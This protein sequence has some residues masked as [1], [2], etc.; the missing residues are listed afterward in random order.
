[1]KLYPDILVAYTFAD[2]TEEQILKYE[3]RINGYPA[4]Y[5]EVIKTS[6]MFLCELFYENKKWVLK[7]ALIPNYFF[8]SNLLSSIT[9][10][11]KVPWKIK[12]NNWSIDKTKNGELLQVQ[13][14]KKLNRDV[15]HDTATG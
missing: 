14:I 12:N 6:Q 9:S 11:A 1:M 2:T 13:S 4:W 7:V 10:S 5:G 15:E 3:E 8:D